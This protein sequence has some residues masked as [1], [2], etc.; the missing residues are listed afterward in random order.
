MAD[1]QLAAELLGEVVLPSVLEPVSL[2]PE[3]EPVVRE[4]AD[5]GSWVLRI[6][7]HVTVHS[8]PVGVQ[9]SP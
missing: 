5:G 8:L 4:T 9:L 7:P 6:L 2:G 1:K 3:P